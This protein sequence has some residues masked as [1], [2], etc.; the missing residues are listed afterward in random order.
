[1]SHQGLDL[2]NGRGQVDATKE[3]LVAVAE[4]EHAAQ[5]AFVVVGE[6]AMGSEG[7]GFAE[8]A[9]EAVPPG[10]VS[11]VE[12]MQIELVMDGVMFR[13]LEEVAH[14]VRRA[15]I[16]VIEVLAEDGKDVVPGSAG[17]GSAEE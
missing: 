15:E 14:P 7:V 16:A 4:E 2:V 8:G 17:H 5:V 10:D 9:E 12:A 1:M 6:A 11:V 13:A 3:G